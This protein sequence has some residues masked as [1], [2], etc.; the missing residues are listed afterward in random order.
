[1]ETPQQ[2]LVAE[3]AGTWDGSLSQT[4]LGKPLRTLWRR[5]PPLR[6]DAIEA[7]VFHW[8]AL[9]ATHVHPTTQHK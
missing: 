9:G 7:A 5:Q 8:W 6:G 2:G 4:A 1:M 3:V